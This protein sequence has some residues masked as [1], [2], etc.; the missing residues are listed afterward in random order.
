MEG[1]QKKHAS[2]LY[3]HILFFGVYDF[4]YQISGVTNTVDLLVLRSQELETAIW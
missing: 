4:S 3:D 2:G 1:N